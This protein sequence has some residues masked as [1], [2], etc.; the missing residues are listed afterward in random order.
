VKGIKTML[1]VETEKLGSV[2]VVSLEGRLVRGET[3]A[4]RR[5]V[6]S[7]RDASAV[8][9]DLARVSIIDAGGLGLMLELRQCT[10]SRGI[11]FRLKNVTKL[12]KEVL[13]ITRLE[14]VFVITAETGKSSIPFARP[15][16]RRFQTSAC[17]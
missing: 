5:A 14:S 4:V 3:D 9:I 12:V 15:T 17:A 7:E 16:A 13:E 11:E 6:L 8:V 10:E 1:K 2:S